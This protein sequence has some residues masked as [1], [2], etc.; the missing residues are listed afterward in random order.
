MFVQVITAKVADPAG[1]RAALDRWVQEL[2]PGADGWL[3]STTGV[4]DDGQLVAIA[5]F[6][7]EAAAR[8]NSDRPEQG[9]WWANTAKLFDGEATFRDSENVVPDVRGN[10]DEAG[11]VQVM[12]GE[13]G[14]DADRAQALMNEN[15]DE[16]AAFRPEI[17]GSLGITHSD[18]TWTMVLYFTSEADARE[19]E[20]K[21]PPPELQ[22]QMAEMDKLSVGVPTFLDL[23]DPW[24]SSP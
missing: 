14:P 3:G 7:S 15:P 19:G 2:A 13:Q 18:G 1:A 24:L 12:Q 10:P 22:A 9:E 23:R 4:T 16:W 8:R 20:S 11:F 21:E 5:R 6:D 17:L